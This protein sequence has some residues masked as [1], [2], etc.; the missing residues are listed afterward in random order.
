MR[1]LGGKTFGVTN[2]RTNVCP[3][4]YLLQLCPKICHAENLCVDNACAVEKSGMKYPLNLTIVDLF[5][6]M[7]M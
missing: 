6:D 4:N 5:E 3:N 7:K 1:T 2:F